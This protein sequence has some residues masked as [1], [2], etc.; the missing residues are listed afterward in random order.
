MSHMPVNHP[1]R[2]AYRVLAALIG[3]A[4]LVFGVLSLI[5]AWGDPFFD[6][7]DVTV[8]GLHT[9]LAFG[10]LTVIVGG[11]VLVASILGGNL[12]HLVSLG[13]GGVM[14]IGSLMQLAMVNSGANK[15]NF[16]VGAA[17]VGMVLGMF[18]VCAGLYTR[19]GP[20]ELARSEERYRHH[21][22]AA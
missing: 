20:A 5:R 15:L 14:V 19:T 6:R 11:A 4:V 1:L 8:F 2:G 10:L 16:T 18:L 9:N 7:G 21:R 17:A 3:L 22:A 13:G 12:V